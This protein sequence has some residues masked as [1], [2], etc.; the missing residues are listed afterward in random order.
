VIHAVM[1][2]RFAERAVVGNDRGVGLEQGR[3]RG[4]GT[5]FF[6]LTGY[7]C[8]GGQGSLPGGA[9]VFSVFA[10]G[11]FQDVYRIGMGILS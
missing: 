6:G 10:E 8:T 7:F 5:L 4:I 1:M 3:I 2:W 11:F 9:L